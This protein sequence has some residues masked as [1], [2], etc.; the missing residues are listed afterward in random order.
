[1]AYRKKLDLI[2]K[3]NP[4][5]VIV[6]ECEKLG[7]QTPS[8]LW[9]GD[10]ENKGIGIF[11]YNNFKIEP[12]PKYNPLFRYII[13]LKVAGLISFNL[14]AVWTMNDAEDM[15]K[16]YIGQLWLALDYYKRLL[17]EPTIIIGDFNWNTIW[18][19][20]PS[21]PLYGNLSDMIK[22]LASKGFQS[23]YHAF[24][25][26]EF[27]KETKPTLFMHHNR[28]KPYHVD[29]CFAS[30]N[31]GLEIVE[32]GDYSDWVNYSDHMPLIA[33]FKKPQN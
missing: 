30:K 21:Y 27:G 32:I 1:M 19:A 24:F 26:E 14:L 13:P 17:D 23:A 20:K 7:E 10:N 11:S 33:T 8:R 25:R 9:Y 5:I 16:R 6:P 18:D 15:R 31:F 4:D 2:L 3:F 28:D 22:I 29:Y 12:N